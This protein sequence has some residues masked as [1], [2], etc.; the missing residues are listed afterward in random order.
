[1]EENFFLQVLHTTK[2]GIANECIIHY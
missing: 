2:L 1:M